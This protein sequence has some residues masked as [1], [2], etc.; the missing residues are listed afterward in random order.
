MTLRLL[1]PLYAWQQW[2][3]CY[4]PSNDELAS[5]SEDE[6]ESWREEEERYSEYA[7]MREAGH[8]VWRTYGWGDHMHLCVGDYP[9]DG[10]HTL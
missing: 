8:S 6:Y 4:E 3:R 1:E 5:M 10:R 9:S 2:P 7:E